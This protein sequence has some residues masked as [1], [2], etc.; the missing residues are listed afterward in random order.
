MAVI[1]PIVSKFDDKGLKQAQ[2]DF[3]KLGKSMKTM[4]AGVGVGLGLAA[5]TNGLQAA[6]KAAASDAK[7]QGLLAL[8]MKNTMGATAEQISMAEKNIKAMELMSSVADDQIRPAFAN[9]AAV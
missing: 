2:S 9:L 6:G 7:S 8:A 5:L 3:G 4:L 1:V